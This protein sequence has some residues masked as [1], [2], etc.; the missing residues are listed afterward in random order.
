[1][2]DINEVI[3]RKE[4]ELQQLQ[5]DV[6]SLRIAVRLLSEDGDSSTAYVPRPAT[7][8]DPYGSTV[9]QA[10]TPTSS[11]AYADPWDSAVKKFP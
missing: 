8:A 3:R 7:L 2:K 10:S 11:T 9:R 5:R 1:M 4:A 6:E